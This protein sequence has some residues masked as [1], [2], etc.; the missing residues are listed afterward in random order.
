MQRGGIHCENP[1][2]EGGSRGRDVRLLHS[3]KSPST[4]ISLSGGVTRASTE[5]TI[6]TTRLRFS[7]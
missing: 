1:Q 6:E 4:G 3:I 7:G 2:E 5:L